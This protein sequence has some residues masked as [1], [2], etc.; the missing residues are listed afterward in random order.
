MD[1]ESQSQALPGQSEDKSLKLIENN[2]RNNLDSNYTEKIEELDKSFKYSDNS[3]CYWS[4]PEL[5]LL[6]GTPL[7]AEA[8]P[9]QKLALNHLFWV[10]QYNYTALSE[11][12]V[13]HYNHITAGSF[14]AMGGEY[15]ALA[16]QLEH[17]ALQERSH[18]HAFYRVNYQTMTALLGKQAFSKP[19]EKKLQQP[20]GSGSQLPT[21]QYYALRSLSKLMLKNKEQYHSQYLK[22]FEEKNK[23]STLTNGFFHGRGIVPQSLIRFFAFN[24]GSSPFLASQYYTVRYM[25]NMLLKH[26]EHGIFLYFKKLQKQDEFVPVPTAISH[27]HFLDEAF[28]TTTSLFLGRELH[29]HVPKPTAYEK[30]VVNMTVYMAQKGNFNG[31]SG[32]VNKRCFGDD[33]ALMTDLYKLLQSPLF[34]MSSPDA[35]AWMQKCLCQ[36]HEGFHINLNAYK[37]LLTELRRAFVDMD[38]LWPV[39]REM[40]VMASGGS[41][42]QAIQSNIKLFDQF[43]IEQLSRA[44]A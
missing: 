7:Y 34:G 38:Y 27:Y 20:K 33:K 36:E 15:Q 17:E 44:A 3:H 9:A 19:S 16:K 8:S 10:S 6:Y 2:Y 11:A 32:V 5:S 26:V 29:Q 40:R 30:A 39:N 14:L 22:D 31:V 24:W 41:V 18:I 35:L 13:V 25:A 43:S 12:E 28:H 23:L 21:Y 1:A 37:R 42:S 4:E